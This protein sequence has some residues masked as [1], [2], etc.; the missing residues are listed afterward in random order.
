M[1]GKRAK[2]FSMISR[3]SSVGIRSR[4]ASPLAASP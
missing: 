3:A 2:Y 1:P 4:K